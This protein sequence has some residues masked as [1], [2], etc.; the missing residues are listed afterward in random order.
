ML[1]LRGQLQ[2]EL[3]KQPLP[4]THQIFIGRVL[5]EGGQHVVEVLLVDE[6]VTVLELDILVNK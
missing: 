3:N 5:A 4:S 1:K 6:A 2:F